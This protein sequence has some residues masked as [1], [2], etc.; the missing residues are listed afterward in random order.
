MKETK[1]ANR[2]LARIIIEAETP[3][4]VGSGEKSLT[5]DAEIARDVNGMPYIP[6]TALA[7]VIRHALG[8]ETAKEFFGYQQGK[9]GKGSEII[10]SDAVM[11]GKEG[12]VLDG[13]LDLDSEDGFYQKFFDLPIR[14]HVR[15]N[16]F[17]AAE[18]N[19]KFD[20]RVLYKGVRF[21]FEIEQL[22]KS[23][24]DYETKFKNALSK[25][26]S[27]DF[28]LGGGTRSGFG[29]MKIISCKTVNLDLTKQEDLH[30]YLDKDSSLSSEWTGYKE[31]FSESEDS[32]ELTVYELDLQPNDF[33]LFGSGF[34]DD[35][36]DMTPVKEDIV[37][38][39]PQGKPHFKENNV[40]IPASSVKGALSHRVAY[41]YNK[42]AGIYSDG[43]S[44]DDM[45]QHTGKNNPAV[46]SLF[47]SEEG[48]D[49]TP[50]RGKVILSDIIE[51]NEGIK[52]KLLN[53]VSI[54]RFTGGAI[55]GALFSEK[56]TYGKGKTFKTTIIVENEAF[57]TEEVKNAFE[58]SIKDI[59][60]GMLP[61]GGGINRGNGTFKG[62]ILRNGEQL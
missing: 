21:C 31:E 61:L 14:Q 17:G 44:E 45:K 60:S 25:L 2:F 22:A 59:A 51:S 49:G 24:S 55:D 48:E 9:D 5:T 11:I 53:H 57:K 20:E 41:Y 8:E 52:D 4:A 36:A 47:G 35:Q 6:G 23:S 40:L 27:K 38:W 26:Y 32:G 39:D 62:K 16:S 58:R 50:I 3:L 12:E 28:R 30:S 19:G 54:D 7:G 42:A 18:D 33:F 15:I 1:Y 56:A 29:E 46:R 13:L 37:T 34:G 10:F 43:M